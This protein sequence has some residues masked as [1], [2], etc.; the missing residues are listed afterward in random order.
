MTKGKS[1]KVSKNKRH[2]RTQKNSK[3]ENDNCK[4]TLLV[5]ILIIEFIFFLILLVSVNLIMA[6]KAQ[7]AKGWR[8]D[9]GSLTIQQ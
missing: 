4:P 2:M 8:T 1:L 3:E 6:G 7:I 5:F 9:I